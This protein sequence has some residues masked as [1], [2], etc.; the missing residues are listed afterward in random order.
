MA[1]DRSSA[2]AAELVAGR[3]WSPGAEEARRRGSREMV[4]GGR[5]SVLGA[6]SVG[7][8]LQTREGER[9]AMVWLGGAKSKVEALGCGGWWDGDPDE[10][11]GVAAAEWGWD[12]APNF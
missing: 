9:L 11:L 12:K 2:G 1:G 4:G 8:M 3:R 10:D 6:A 5:G 7:L